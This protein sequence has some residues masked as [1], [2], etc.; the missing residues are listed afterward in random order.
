M[1]TGD[2]RLAVDTQNNKIFSLLHPMLY[3]RI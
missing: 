2:R 3:S 1:Y